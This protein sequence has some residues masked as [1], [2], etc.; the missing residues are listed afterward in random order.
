MKVKLLKTIEL[1]QQRPALLVHESLVYKVQ[2]HGTC[3]FVLQR[4]KWDHCY[5]FNIP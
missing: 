2:M 5:S 4:S 1:Y 3:P